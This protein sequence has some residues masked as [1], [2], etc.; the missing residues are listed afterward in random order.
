MA[1]RSSLRDRIYDSYTWQEKYGDPGFHRHV[2]QLPISEPIGLRS[3]QVA[4][5]KVLGLMALR[6]ADDIVL[7]LNISQYSLELSSYLQK[8]ASIAESLKVSDQLDFG[9][10][11]ESIVRV[12][13]AS[14]ALDK[15]A[16]KALEKLHKLVPRVPRGPH[17]KKGIAGPWKKVLH[18]VQ[19]TLGVEDNHNHRSGG[20]HDRPRLLH[21]ENHEHRDEKHPHDHEHH[22]P[23][24]E[25][26]HKGPHHKHG[27]R[28]PHHRH[29][30]KNPHP[31]PHPP[32]PDPKKVKAIK[33][34]LLEI[35]GINQKLKGYES[36]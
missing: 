30:K 15:Q 11:K 16:A 34:V 14:A 18:L 13:N 19:S 1:M 28:G 25:H 3:F 4:A 32:M 35:R 26:G 8:V 33:E 10:L 6:V 7:P 27:H 21:H 5:A 9:G 17:H 22:G 12:Q 24:H 2:S 23:H 36:G 31:H 29:G 20:H